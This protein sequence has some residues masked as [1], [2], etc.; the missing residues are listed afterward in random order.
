MGEYRLKRN[1][2]SQFIWS[3]RCKMVV[4]ERNKLRNRCNV[5][6][7][8]TTY[9]KIRSETPIV[10]LFLSY[11][12]EFKPGISFEQAHFSFLVKN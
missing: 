12:Y 4:E 2:L 9:S 8:V 10:G 3:S 11:Y 6:V 5:L 7:V 1:A